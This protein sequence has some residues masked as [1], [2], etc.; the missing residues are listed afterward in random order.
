MTAIDPAVELMRLT[1]G[2]QVSQAIHIAATLGVADL[3]EDKPRSNDELASLTG[4]HN[5][6][7][8]RLLR[9]L[10]SVGVFHEDDKRQFS[11][12]PM[13]RCLRSDSET[14]VGPWAVLI[15]RPYI[16]QAWAHLLHSVRT[17]ENAFRHLHG[18][19]VWTFRAQHPEEGAIFDQ[20]M[21]A[22]SRSVVDALVSAYDF[23]GHSHIVDVG[24]GQG[25]LLAGI[26]SALPQ[27]RGTL[28]DQPHV[29][30][31]A[32]DLL[33]RENVTDRCDVI[34]GSFFEGIP[35]NGDTY[36]LK[37]I[38]HDWDDDATLSILRICRQS[39]SIGRKLL[40]VERL[41]APPNA[42]PN[43]K[44]SDLNMLVL[45]GGAERT[46]QEFESLLTAANFRLIRTMPAGPTLTIIE[47]E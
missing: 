15:G 19:S 2:Y 27:I 22:I 31:R 11:L 1:N 30:V 40:I 4:V 7:L 24:G 26:L 13:G 17:G 16:W 29:V 37:G 6:S 38:L 34:A 47:A 44:F 23:S 25:Q 36:I 5:G 28:F 43:G 9:A 45:P 3:L 14:P 41:I 10:A 35:V 46:R 42:A 39:I 12:T 8:Y 32:K 20:A 18:E 21:N 33:A